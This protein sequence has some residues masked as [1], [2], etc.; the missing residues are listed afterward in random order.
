VAI[1]APPR[2]RARRIAG[3]GLSSGDADRLLH[4]YRNAFGCRLLSRERR[5]GAHFE[6]AL[7]VR[8]GAQCVTIGLGRETIEF[9]QFDNPG[10]AYPADVASSDPRFQH[11]A[12]VV[13][14]MGEALQRLSS[15]P[16]WTPISTPGPQR[17][18]RRSGGVTA[19]KFRDIDGHPL[20]LLQFAKHGVPPYWQSSSGGAVFL[21]VDHSAIVVGDTQRSLAFYAA[22][23]LGRITGSDNHG[24]AQSRLDGVPDAQVEVTAVAPA[25]ATPHLELLCYRGKARPP[26][27]VAPIP[28]SNDVAATRLLFE[29]DGPAR[30]LSEDAVERVFLDPDGHRLQFARASA[31]PVAA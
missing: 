8:G 4:F 5:S 21:G 17:L 10:A 3:F 24:I 7:R 14:D 29:A 13:A 2:P 18:P 12:I 16:G 23:G 11:F 20:E 19:F 15:T 26:A 27:P 25:V 28:R 31:A 6:R 1:S 22:L 30:P 9:L